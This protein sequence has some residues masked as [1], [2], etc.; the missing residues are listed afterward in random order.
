MPGRCRCR[1]A[2]ERC[3]GR[4]TAAEGGEGGRRL[5]PVSQS[6]P[7]GL[8]R[9][10]DRLVVAIRLDVAESVGALVED[11]VELTFLDPLVEPGAAEDEPAYPVDEALLGTAH[12]LD[13]VRVHVLA[14]GGGRFA[15][16][17]VDGQL[18]E[19]VKFLGSQAGVGEVEL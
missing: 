8:A 19:I 15:D 6:A 10:L 7:G 17:P 3:R 12:E 13:P 14:E 1:R 9:E 4:T 16:L 18:D 5:T 11:D 2:C